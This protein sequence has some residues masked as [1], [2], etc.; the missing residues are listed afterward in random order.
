MSVAVVC[1]F[2]SRPLDVVDGAYKTYCMKE[3]NTKDI[4]PCLC[5][6]C[7]DKLDEIIAESRTR[8]M[9]LM[10]QGEIAERVTKLNKE[11]REELGTSG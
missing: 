10:K 7:A 4:L 8:L 2:C 6:T 5:K 1:D 3:L 9:K 11:R